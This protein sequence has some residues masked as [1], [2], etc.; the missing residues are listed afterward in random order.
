MIYAKLVP[1]LHCS[2]VE[3]SLDFYTRV[4][5]FRV[6]YARPEERFAY[7]EREGAELMLD[8]SSPPRLVAGVP[9]YPFGRGISL[10]I[11]VSDV[12]ALHADVLAAG[13]TVHLP[14]EERWYRADDQL[15]GNRQF[16]ALD[17]DGYVLRF[18]RDLGLR[19]VRPDEPA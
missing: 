19:P 13:A 15:R 17:P 3:R 16:A 8:Q 14:M 18:Y 4:L 12:D 7:L 10:Q 2:Q 6:V 1:E 5:G 9:E 11:Q